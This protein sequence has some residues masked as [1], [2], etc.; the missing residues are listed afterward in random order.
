MAVFRYYADQLPDEATIQQILSGGNSYEIIERPTTPQ[1]PVSP[2]WYGEGGYAPQLQEITNLRD[3]DSVMANVQ[4]VR[5]AQL[6]FQAAKDKYHQDLLAYNAATMGYATTEGLLAGSNAP[7]PMYGNFPEPTVL[8]RVDPTQPAPQTTPAPTAPQTTQSLPS[9]STSPTSVRSSAEGSGSLDRS[10]DGTRRFRED[11]PYTGLPT[12]TDFYSQRQETRSTPTNQHYNLPYSGPPPAPGGGGTDGSGGTDGTGGTGGAGG[13]GGGGGPAYPGY[14]GFP[15]G[16]YQPGGYFYPAPGVGQTGTYENPPMH[17]ID[18]STYPRLGSVPVDVPDYAKQDR[19]YFAHRGEMLNTDLAAYINE[20]NWLAAVYGGRADLAYSPMEAGGGGYAEDEANAIMRDSE[21]RALWMS[22]EEAQ[23]NFLTADEMTRWTGDPARLRQSFNVPYIEGVLGSVAGQMRGTLDTYEPSM[24]DSVNEYGVRLRGTMDPNLL[25]YAGAAG[26]DAALQQGE[27]AVRSYI[28]P[29]RLGLSQ[30]YLDNYRFTA[31]DERRITERAAR[32]E[33]QETQAQLDR[34]R[35][36]AAAQGNTSPLALAAAEDRAR[37][38]GA[39]G[40]GDAVRDARIGARQLALDTTQRREDT[41][42]DAERGYAAL[43]TTNEQELAARRLAQLN[44]QERMRL[45]AEQGIADRNREIET[46]AGRSRLATEAD[47]MRQRVAA[48]QWLGNT[49]MDTTKYITSGVRDLESYIENLESTRA[50]EM[51]RNRQ[52][53]EQANQQQYFARGMTAG[54]AASDRARAIADTRQGAQREYRG[55][56]TGQKQQASDNVN[57]G[58]QQQLSG[59]ATQGALQGSATQQAQNWEHTI[60]GRMGNNPASLW[61]KILSGAIG[62]I[63]AVT[64]GGGFPG[65]NGSK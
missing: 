63:G 2:T 29:N 1:A 49:T 33:G 5:D 41:R 42:L 13:A 64:G 28:D 9:Y 46:E 11:V 10:G 4:A 54:Q 43:G 60:A 35:Q 55:Y 14:G 59:Y 45:A 61:E 20:Q 48:E 21:L 15:S 8:D 17:Q 7:V 44:E 31:D 3:T 37:L 47:L 58:R 38:T 6:A 18:F 34:I 32:S 25:R 26:S 39:I 53:V 27:S 19:D 36:A 24:R 57:T 50:A 56:L 23:R 16:T 52:A 22:P 65:L 12:I 51:A 40:A 30:E 62:A